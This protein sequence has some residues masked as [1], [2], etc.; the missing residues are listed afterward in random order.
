MV[1]QQPRQH[2]Q[3][4][5]PGPQGYQQPGP[6]P[7]GYP[8]PGYQ[9]AAPPKRN[10][11]ARHKIISTL[12]AIVGVIM[13]IGAIG[14]GSSDSAAPID[15]AVVAGD[16]SVG[17]DTGEPAPQEA[18]PD[19]SDQKD[20]SAS[21]AG[22]GDTVRAGDLRLTVAEP[23]CGK[24]KVGSDYTE[25]RAQ[26]QFCIVTVDITNAGDSPVMITDSDFSLY[27][28]Q[29]REFATD[30]EAMIWNAE[31]S[32]IWLEEINPG[33]KVSGDLIFDIPEDADAARLELASSDLFGEP[34]VIK[35]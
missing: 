26:G 23:S 1:H 7:P 19:K 25:A 5:Q 6:P 2:D 21:T 31:S 9:P 16:G 17:T 28:G 18:D 30:S 15:N 4:H 11:F 10:W 35:L 27:D 34:A 24:K 22:V 12:L 13:I 14:N 20:K 33:N 29:D 3:Q 32:D 8:Q